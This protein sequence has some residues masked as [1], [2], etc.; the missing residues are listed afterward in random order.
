[1][2]YGNLGSPYGGLPSFNSYAPPAS[3]G[4]GTGIDVMKGF[5]S[6]GGFST[7]D[8]L[9]GFS[10]SPLAGAAQGGSGLW[11]GLGE[12]FGNHGKTLVGGLGALGGLFMNTR[13]YG[14]AKD[15]LNMQR[16]AYDKNYAAQRQMTNARLEDRQ[17]AR[18]AGSIGHLGT[19]EYM[20]RYGV[21]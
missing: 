15:Q 4:Y 19:E 7:P 10:G 21:K 14:L 3:G 1:M 8:A 16:E 9:N 12:F 13:N 18:N 6:T 17:R 11:D 20:D 5:G 2:A